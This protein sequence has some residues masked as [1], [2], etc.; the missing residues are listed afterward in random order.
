MN[1]VAVVLDEETHEAVLGHQDFIGLARAGLSLDAGISRIVSLHRW[2]ETTVENTARGAPTKK[3]CQGSVTA[4]GRCL[5]PY[6]SH[7]DELL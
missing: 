1:W 3:F 6:T 7:M 5:F 2:M 4:S